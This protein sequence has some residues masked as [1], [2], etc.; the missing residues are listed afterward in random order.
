MVRET[1]LLNISF[2]SFFPEPSVTLTIPL[3]LSQISLSQDWL[4]YAAVT[5]NSKISLD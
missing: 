2:A 1:L 4:H 5:N 3:K